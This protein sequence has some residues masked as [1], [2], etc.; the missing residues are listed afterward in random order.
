MIKWLIEVRKPIDRDAVVSRHL[1]YVVI[2]A[3]FLV[4]ARLLPKG[5]GV[6]P[7]CMFKRITGFPCMFCGYTRAFQHMAHG[8]F[9]V[10]LVD[11]PAAIVLFIFMMTVFL[12]NLTGLLTGRVIELGYVFRIERRRF[13]SAGVI[14]F[15]ILNWIYRLAN[16]FS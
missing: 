8:E 13:V 3:P 5:V 4:V 2:T 15:F 6:V 1:P 7:G 9:G 12:F 16:G 14:A 10:V 11:N